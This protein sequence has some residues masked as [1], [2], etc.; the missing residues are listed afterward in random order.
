MSIP[1]TLTAVDLWTDGACSGN[2][3]KA[4]SPGGWAAILVTGAHHMELSGG[5]ADTTNNRMEIVGVVNGLKAL[6][7]PCRVR[8]HTDS[9]YVMN[10]ATKWIHGWKRRGWKTAA[11][12]PVA[13]RELFEEL[14]AEL[15]RHTVEWV[16]V[17]GHRGV[18]LNERADR[19]AVAACER[20]GKRR[21][22]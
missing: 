16:K 21:A 12:K 10:S 20:Y 13:N 4:A 18:E 11:G 17:D 9:S 5:E 3:R 1:A 7:R 22:A 2:G 15:R 19:L 14:D 8:I 6:D